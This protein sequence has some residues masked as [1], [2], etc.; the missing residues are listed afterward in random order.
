VLSYRGKTTLLTVE[1]RVAGAAG[2]RP[3]LAGVGGGR[4]LEGLRERL[5]R[6]GGSMR[7]GA[8]GGGWRVELEVPG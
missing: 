7:A 4:G 8:V 2:S 6:V 1:D 5:E 3:G